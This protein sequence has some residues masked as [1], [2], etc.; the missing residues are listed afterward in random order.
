M[1]FQIIEFERKPARG[2]GPWYTVQIDRD[3]L[4]RY[5][6]NFF[7]LRR[8]NF[9]WRLAR[10]SLESLDELLAGLD[11]TSIRQRKP[12]FLRTC[13]ASS[14]L[15]VRY[16]DGLLHTVNHG[17]LDERYPNELYGAEGKLEQIAHILPMIK[18]DGEES[19]FLLV[20]E[21]NLDTG[22]DCH[23][24]SAAHEA[25]ARQLVQETIYR[26]RRR[27]VDLSNWQCIYLGPTLPRRHPRPFIYLSRLKEFPE[28]IKSLPQAEIQDNGPH[29]IFLVMPERV[30][31]NALC[32]DIHAVIAETEDA[33][34]ELVRSAI[35]RG[36]RRKH[37]TASRLA[38]LTNSTF[39]RAFIASRPRTKYRPR[40]DW[41]L[42]CA[43]PLIGKDAQDDPPSRQQ[44]LD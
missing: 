6:G 43:F 4:V 15:T 16:E 31:F 14:R 39:R 37:L 10:A 44:S 20:E 38:T 9:S 5:F 21:S 32:S 11:F 24:V 41:E 29:F 19:V 28:P 1:G 12:V 2:G 35:Y 27:P 26:C 13:G 34:I 22:Q 7:V 3:G 8:G 33:A 40:V 30:R 23:V 18:G 25:D 17:P 36:N 42:A